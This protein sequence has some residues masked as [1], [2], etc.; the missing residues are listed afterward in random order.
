[1]RAKEGA[2]KSGSLDATA[3]NAAWSTMPSASSDW[4][5]KTSLHSARLRS[6]WVAIAS[7]IYLV[8]PGAGAVCSILRGGLGGGGLGVSRSNRGFRRGSVARRRARNRRDRS[9]ATRSPTT[10]VSPR[11]RRRSGADADKNRKSE[12]SGEK[13]HRRV[14]DA[15]LPCLGPPSRRVS[16]IEEA[17]GRRGGRWGRAH[18]F[19]ART[20]TSRPLVAV[21]MGPDPARRKISLGLR[22]LAW[23]DRDEAFRIGVALFMVRLL[24][25]YVCRTVFETKMSNCIPHVRIKNPQIQSRLPTRSPQQ[26][27]ANTPPIQSRCA[28][29]RA[30][31]RS[32]RST[33][34]LVDRRHVFAQPRGRAADVAGQAAVPA[35]GRRRG[36]SG[37]GDAAAAEASGSSGFSTAGEDDGSPGP[38]GKRAAHATRRQAFPRFVLQGHQRRS[39]ARREALHGA[40]PAP[41][42]CSSKPRPR[43]RPA[44]SSVC[45]RHTAD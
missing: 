5:S 42:D 44:P 2:K 20:V 24:T 7:V 17:L 28:R 38:T 9:G 36:G 14:Q 8:S 18:L 13:A 21:G 39:R 22:G 11:N 4:I 41:I 34:V 12:A 10:R 32:V 6:A 40:S 3:T 29:S 25:D 37:S 31:V 26:R 35:R 16:G 43:P 1:M 45:A 15:S 27:R 19:R 30:A 33:G 23:Q